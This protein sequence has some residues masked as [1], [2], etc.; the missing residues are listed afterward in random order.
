LAPQWQGLA[1]MPLPGKE[2]DPGV[3]VVAD[4]SP[5]GGERG[6]RLGAVAIGKTAAKPLQPARGGKVKGLQGC[7]GETL[8]I[9]FAGVGPVF[10]GVAQEADRHVL[11]VDRTAGPA[12]QVKQVRA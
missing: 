7:V 2:N 4:V 11:Q 9:E 1:A 12:A 8:E 5:G 10:G 6:V 3:T